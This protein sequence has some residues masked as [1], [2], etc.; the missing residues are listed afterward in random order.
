M[1]VTKMQSKRWSS[2]AAWLA[3]LAVLSS[4]VAVA[5][6]RP[7]H[8]HHNRDLHPATPADVVER[9]A[10]ATVFPAARRRAA[11][12]AAGAVDEQEAHAFERRAPGPAAAAPTPLS[13]H[14]QRHL[15]HVHAARRDHKKRLLGFPTDDSSSK[16]AAASSSEALASSSSLEQSLSDSIASS[17]ASS[18]AAASSSSAAAAAAASSSSAAA[19]AA[20]ASSSSRAASI[21]ASKSSVSASIQASLS[22]QALQ[23]SLAASI[24]SQFLQSTITSYTTATPS[25]TAQSDSSSTGSSDGHTSLIIG[26]SVVGGAALLGLLAFLYMKFG[27]K[28]FSNYDEDDH[29]IKWPELRSEGDTAAMHPLPARRTGG[30]GFE[31]AGESDNGHDRDMVEHDMHGGYGRDSFSGS[32]TALGAAASGAAGYGA[33]GTAASAGAYHDVDAQSATQG[34]AAPHNGYY[35]QYGQAV[36][37]YSDAGNPYT[38]AHAASAYGSVPASSQGYYDPGA[39][40]GAGQAHYVQDPYQQQAAQQHSMTS[41]P[42]QATHTGYGGH[43]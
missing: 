32:T 12:P 29:D 25:A 35:D 17:I 22:Q 11:Q 16:D 34:Y 33:Y 38:D 8:P 4:A 41:P 19:A 5:A 30:A 40:A 18:I 3:V 10:Q 21:A 37:G 7:A 27:Q 24:T 1:R 42:M 20:A 31:M 23:S 13:A 28:R 9:Q 6:E 15:S 39:G 43:M 2:F 14:L 36:P 26:V